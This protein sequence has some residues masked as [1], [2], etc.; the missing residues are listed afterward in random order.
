MERRAGALLLDAAGCCWFSHTLPLIP[1]R[2]QT[3]GSRYTPACSMLKE[4]SGCL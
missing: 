1:S 3:L 2:T 4:T